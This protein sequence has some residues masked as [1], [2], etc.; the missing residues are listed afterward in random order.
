M[1][2]SH[3]VKPLLRIRIRTFS[4]PDPDPNIFSSGSG[5]KHFF[6]LDPWS[7]VKSGMLF[8]WFLWFQFQEQ[9]LS[10]SH[11]CSQKDPR[12]GKNSSRIRILGPKGKKHRIPDLDLQ[13]CVK[14]YIVNYVYQCCGSGMVY[15]GSRIRIRPLLHPGSDHCSIPDPGGKN[16][17]DPGSYCT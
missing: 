5:S 7:Y 11:T 15:P 2:V 8:S 16:A 3:N 6:I 14:M 10:L 12:S 9:S 4:H 17:P 13:Y 1:N